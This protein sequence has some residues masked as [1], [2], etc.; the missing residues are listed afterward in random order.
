MQEIHENGPSLETRVREESANQIKINETESRQQMLLQ[1]QQMQ[2]I[3]DLFAKNSTKPVKVSSVVVNNAESIR[4]SVL[5]S[6]LDATINQALNFQQLV[7]Q[8][9]TLH[10]KL[11]SN[12]LVEDVSQTLDSRGSFQVPV[13]QTQLPGLMYKFDIPTSISVLD[14]VPTLQLQP[15]KK[16][17]AK[18]GTNIGN[19]EGDGYLQFQWRNVLGGGEKFTFDATKGTKTHS[20]Y[21]LNFTQPISPWWLWDSI[22]FKNSRQMG[23]AELFLRG[24]RTTLKSGF[25]GDL[26]VNHE[27]HWENLWRSTKATSTHASDYLLFQGGDDLKSSLC[28]IMTIDDRDNAISPTRGNYAKLLN[29]L[30][31]GKFWKTTLEFSRTNSWFTN[32][33]ITMTGTF[34]GGYISN[35]HPKSQPLHMGDKFH[36][37]GSNDVR[38]FQ[39]MGLGPKD[40]Y[41][42]MGGDAFVAYGVSLFSRL[43]VRR[44]YESNFRLHWFVNGGRLINHNNTNLSSCIKSLT[45]EHSTSTGVGL[46]FKHPVARFELNFTVPISAHSSDSVR[47]GFQYGIGLTFL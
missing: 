44:W 31:L 42:S 36:N 22:I 19:G 43:P 33:F 47:K 40:L 27:L 39:A 8:S 4:P 46:V 26:P 12:G 16:F 20:S 41:D 28:H 29:E 10:Y 35:F 45:Q 30:A 23:Q 11:V 2:Y 13:T 32:D 9:D 15:I 38:G 7:K 17:S 18:T 3:T 37:G 25:Y 5:Q 34:K 1:S 6:Y 21:L 14:I 24:I